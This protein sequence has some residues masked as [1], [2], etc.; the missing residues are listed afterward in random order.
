[1][2]N[3]ESTRQS[4]PL[5]SIAK[6][7][8]HTVSSMFASGNGQRTSATRKLAT[9]LGWF[10]IGLGV[11]ELV[12]TR[13]VARFTRLDGRERLLE[14]YGLREIASGIAIL[15]LPDARTKTLAMWSRVAGDALD[16][17]TLGGAAMRSRRRGG[18]PLAAIAAVAGVTA[19]DLACARTLG[20]EAQAAGQTTD[21]SARSGIPAPPAQM[22]GAA[23]KTFKQP[24]DMRLAPQRNANGAGGARGEEE[25]P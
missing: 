18:H 16:L 23:L 21:Y 8:I 10:S 2:A 12:A 5:D 24:R 20:Q 14:T 6:S 9:G 22:R 1:M 4:S 13:R 25:A 19:L 7:V 17:A 11:L 3:P 15:M